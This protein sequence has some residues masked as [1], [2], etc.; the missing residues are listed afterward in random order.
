MSTVS[1]QISNLAPDEKRK[2]V[3]RLLRQRAGEAV[4]F[5]PLSQGQRSLWFE[6]KLFPQSTAY[7]ITFAAR[8]V[9]S[10][11]AQLLQRGFQMLV[12][13]H[14]SLRTTFATRS[15]E[16]VQAI[17]AF[18]PV[19]F[20]VVE[21]SSRS[22]N[23]L[24]A[25]LLQASAQPFDL[26]RGP[27]MRV[28]LF[29]RAAEQSIL[30]LTV[31]HLIGDFWS[32][33][34]MMEELARWY[35]AES[36]SNHI[37][38][39]TAQLQYI[40][41][42]NWQAEM[43]ASP[44]G[45]RLWSYW[46]E[47]L[48]GELP[49]INLPADK[50]RPPIQTHRGA[51]H[52]FKVDRE[53]SNKLKEFVKLETTTP[54]VVVLAAFQCLLHRYSG[55]NE[56][57]VGSPAAGRDRAGLAE[58][59]GYFAN[60]VVM[61]TD[62]SGNPSFR[63]LLQ[64]VRQTV[65][66]AMEHEMFP[67]PVLVE[68]LRPA[69]DLSSSPLFQVMFVLER[70]HR[71]SLEG[72]SLFIMGEPGARLDLS[73]LVLESFDL[74]P[75]TV[76]FDLTLM[77]ESVNETFVAALQYSTDL[78]EAETIERMAGH[79]QVLLEAVVANPATRV[80]ELP[81]LTAGER[82]QLVQ[83]WN[84]TAC[85]YPSEESVAQ[86]IEAQVKANAAAIAVEYEG[87]ELSYGELNERANQ[88]AHELRRLGVKAETHVGICLERS[89][90]MLIAVLGIWKAGGAYVPLDP[91]YPEARLQFMVADAQLKVLVT[92]AVHVEK[93]QCEG[94]TVLCLEREQAR[95]A[96]QS[97]ENPE[98]SVNGAH[99]AYMIYTSGS[100]GQPKG[101]Q[102]T[103]R[104]LQNFLATMLTEPGLNERDQ[105]LAVTTLSFDIAGLELYLPLL[106]GARVIVA[107]RRQASDGQELRRRLSAGGVTVMQA[108]P[109][110]WRMLLESGWEGTEPL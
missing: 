17:H 90:Q 19:E 14:P 88:L 69:R 43:L 58:V 49:N 107:S 38:L 96:R 76:Q 50:P 7:N 106:V 87:R 60:P 101:V 22:G 20:E 1:E 18:M 78:F 91:Q 56:I 95:L 44:E 45:E 39:P 98:P 5:H 84:D 51:S 48:A 24:K 31:H 9:S 73:G 70:S 64:N 30:L 15:E 72:A 10:F 89:E 62:F 86:S 54:Y 108:T 74:K 42:V 99:L 32:L 65:L 29:T 94:V 2:L 55:Q 26:E 59:V 109:A 52:T 37:D 83:S 104:A 12:D 66:E 53:L 27:L 41:Y 13:R 35:A 80:Q 103:H 105:M 57:L 40:D 46:K 8:I 85:L 47:K 36:K 11:D 3:A 71:T 100:T 110:T 25:D 81:L 6:A 92:E 61:R 28:N 23:E 33:V 4:S 67:F 97:R 16:P 93:L 82:E 77:L 79:L 68:R 75:Q 34:I 21:A 63:E 102:I